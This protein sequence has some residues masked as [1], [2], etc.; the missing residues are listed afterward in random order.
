MPKSISAITYGELIYG[1]RKSRHVERN[2]AVS[3]RIDAFDSLGFKDAEAKL[4]EVVTLC[5]E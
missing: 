5:E 1:D 2:K 3:Y 4:T